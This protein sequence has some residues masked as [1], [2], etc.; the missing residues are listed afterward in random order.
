MYWH[1]VKPLVMFQAWLKYFSI[2]VPYVPI[3]LYACPTSLVSKELRTWGGDETRFLT[4]R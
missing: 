2:E 1:F 3:Y 4:D